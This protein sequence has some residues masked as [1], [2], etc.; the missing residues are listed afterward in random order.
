MF[1]IEVVNKG[2]FHFTPCSTSHTI[3]EGIVK[4]K[5]VVAANSLP[6]KN[7]RIVDETCGDVVWEGN[8]EMSFDDLLRGTHKPTRK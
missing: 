8:K 6:V 5:D 1:S 4:A 3:E 2:E 7:V